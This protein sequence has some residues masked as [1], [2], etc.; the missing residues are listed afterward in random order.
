MKRHIEEENGVEGEESFVKKAR[1]N[2]D[3][4]VPEVPIAEQDSFP[5]LE[6]VD[7]T[8]LSEEA[9]RRKML[10]LMPSARQSHS[11]VSFQNTIL[12]AGGVVTSNSGL[13]EVL[14]SVVEYNLDSKSW[15]EMAPMNHARKFFGLLVV[16]SVVF[17]VGGSV[18]VVNEKGEKFSIADGTMEMLKDGA[19][20]LLPSMEYPRQHC[21]YIT[22]HNH[23][24][25]IGGRS[26]D[27]T[28]ITCIEK[29]NTDSREWSVIP[30]DH[31]NSSA[32][33][34]FYLCEHVVILK[35]IKYFIGGVENRG[36]CFRMESRCDDALM[37]IEQIGSLRAA[38]SFSSVTVY[39]SFI[40]AFGGALDD[41][42]ILC[43]T[44]SFNPQLGVWLYACPLPYRSS[45]SSAV[46]NQNGFVYILGGAGGSRHTLNSFLTY[47]L[48]DIDLAYDVDCFLDTF[49]EGV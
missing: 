15:K 46:T 43:K 36:K 41:D 9:R 4:I 6:P 10:R 37:K 29:F 8:I 16:D 17:A 24:Y 23:I 28:L 47:T 25:A 35:D 42:N 34:D 32:S 49:P 21:M 39:E 20:T 22:E 18:D 27:G 26:D 14:S 48:A 2:E 19:W 44:Q 7:D 5:N 31:R 13:E 12:S 1:P 38:C 33:Y 30:R 3:E 11:S 45:H 40:F